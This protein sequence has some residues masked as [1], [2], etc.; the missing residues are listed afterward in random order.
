M[1]IKNNIFTAEAYLETA[2][3]MI[4]SQDYEGALAVIAKAYEY[5]RAKLEQVNKLQALKAEVKSSAGEDS[6]G[7]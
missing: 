7:P 6:G 4:G 1:D 3:E 2:K 5:T